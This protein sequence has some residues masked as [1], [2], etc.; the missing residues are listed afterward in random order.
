MF[1]KKELKVELEKAREL[2]KQREL[3]ARIAMEQEDAAWAVYEELMNK[4]TEGCNDNE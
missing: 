3:T 4:F 1:D 2:W